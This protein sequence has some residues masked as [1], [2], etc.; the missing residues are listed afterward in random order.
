MN[1]SPMNKSLAIGVVLGA[2]IATVGVV[3]AGYQVVKDDEP[4]IT[5]TR[6]ELAATPTP[7]ECVPTEPRDEHRVAGTVVGAVVGGAV[8][9]DVGD[10]DVTTAAGAAAGAYAGNQIQKKIQEERSDC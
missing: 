5:V 7:P 2:A 8:G 6:P 3:F 10:R 4:A 1:K 9:H